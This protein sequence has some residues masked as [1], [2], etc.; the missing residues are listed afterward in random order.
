M[1][2]LFYIFILLYALK[3][4]CINQTC[5]E[6]SCDEC[7]SPEYGKCTKCRDTFRLLEGKCLCSFSSCS[8]CKSGLAGL[9]IC[10][11]CREGYIHS[12]DECICPINNCEICAVNECQKCNNG[13]YYNSTINEC[14]KLEEKDKISCYDLNCDICFSQEK[15][16]CEICNEGYYEKKGECFELEKPIINNNITTCPNN[17]YL[18]GNYCKERCYGVNCDIF[19]F[20]TKGEQVYLCEYNHCLICKDNEL[21]IFTE[22]DN[23]EECSLLEGCLNCVDNNECLICMQGYFLIGGICKKCIEGCSKCSN[24]INCDYC[25]SGY[26]L[27]QNHICVFTNNFDFNETSYKEIKDN[28]I[29]EEILSQNSINIISSTIIIPTTLITTVPTTIVTEKIKTESPV[30]IN[31]RCNNYC[32]ICNKKKGECERCFSSYYL[33]D[34]KCIKQVSTTIIET[35]PTSLIIHTTHKIIIEETEL[36]CTIENCIN[37]F[38][39]K[40]EEICNKCAYNYFLENKKCKKKCDDKNCVIC[41]EDGL[42]CKECTKDTKLYNGKC[43]EKSDLCLRKNKNCIYCI[44]DDICIECEKDYVIKNHHCYNKKKKKIDFSFIIFLLALIV[45]GFVMVKCYN[46]HSMKIKRKYNGIRHISLDE[47][48]SKNEG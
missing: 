45:L 34:N 28:F 21:W 36:I 42:I 44:D 14:I 30:E 39:S 43:S 31:I 17:Y 19:R 22:C 11:V 23:R 12:N 37:C 2:I 25:L 6:Y 26:Q 7:S 1:K 35:K 16:A 8:L 47:Q 48:Q 29:S 33:I 5:Y 18:I 41:S 10:Y 4:I 32:A 24:Q 38:I 15:G 46:C 27:N 9:N 20:T 13:Y 40:G 3:I